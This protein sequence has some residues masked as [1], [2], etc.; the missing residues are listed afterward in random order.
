LDWVWYLFYLGFHVIVAIG[1]GVLIGRRLP[2]AWLAFLISGIVSTAVFL[3]LFIAECAL[4]CVEYPSD[5]Q[6]PWFYVVG[7]G[8]VLSPFVF[9]AAA[10]LGWIAHDLRKLNRQVQP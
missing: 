1:G 6:S 9:S 5:D 7:Q 2:S 8:V 3:G 10:V 4:W